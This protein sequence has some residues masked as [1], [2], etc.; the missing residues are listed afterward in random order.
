MTVLLELMTV[1]LEYLDLLTEFLH[2]AN[3]LTVKALVS[4]QNQNASIIPNSY[5]YLLC[6][7][8]C[9]HNRRILTGTLV[10]KCHATTS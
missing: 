6:S 5:T 1:L 2:S 8:L 7:K 10:T 9:Q 4:P 3:F